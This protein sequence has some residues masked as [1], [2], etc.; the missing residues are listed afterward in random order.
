[1]MLE[2]SANAPLAPASLAVLRAVAAVAQATSIQATLVGASARDLVLGHV[3]GIP[4]RRATSDIDF[5]VAIPGWEAFDRFVSQIHSEQGFS[6][7]SRTSHRLY[8]QPEETPHRVPIDLIPFGQAVGPGEFRWPQDPDIVMNVEG[9]ADATRA[10]DQVNLGSFYIDVLDLPGLALLKMFAWNDRHSTTRKDANDL[11][12]LIAHHAEAG[13][14]DRLYDGTQGILEAV[15]FDF[16]RGSARLLGRDVRA[17]CSYQT[18]KTLKD[19][20]TD[21]VISRIAADATADQALIEVSANDM[22]RLIADFAS[23]V[24]S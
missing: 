17:I 6:T 10:A 7:A 18:R 4:L 1:M 3:H 16:R 19:I 24:L 5:A 22:H 11:A 13:N 21:A 23:E 15:G 2:V 20:L 8:F 12:V 9:Y 14:M